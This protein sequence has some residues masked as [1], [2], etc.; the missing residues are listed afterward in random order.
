MVADTCLFMVM[1]K[2]YDNSY[3]KSV[4]ILFSAHDM[5]LE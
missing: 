3:N 5:F 1:L 2:F 4:D